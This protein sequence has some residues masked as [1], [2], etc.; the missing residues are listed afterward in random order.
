MMLRPYFL[1]TD[2]KDISMKNSKTL[3][4]LGLA[5]TWLAITFSLAVS[6]QAQTLTYFAQFNGTNGA[7]P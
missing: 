2:S 4:T 3:L 5:L 1:P 6:A 7:Y